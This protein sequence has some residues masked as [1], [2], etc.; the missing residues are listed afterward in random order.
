MKTLISNNHRNYR[1]IWM[2]RIRSTT[3]WV[4]T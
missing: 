3:F 1:T 4:E 2:V